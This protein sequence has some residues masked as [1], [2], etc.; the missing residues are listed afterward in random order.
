MK[1]AWIV[2]I[3]FSLQTVLLSAAPLCEC[4]L[5]EQVTVTSVHCCA[6]EGATCS[7][8]SLPDTEAEPA[9]TATSPTVQL[10]AAPSGMAIFAVSDSRP[11]SLKLT[12]EPHPTGLWS[13]Y[14]CA[15][16]APPLS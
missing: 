12:A 7:M 1:K 14:V 6:D 16:R 11:T 2:A 3:I 5:D 10:V 13:E 8:T 9:V 15:E 4:L